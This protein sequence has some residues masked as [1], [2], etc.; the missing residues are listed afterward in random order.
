MELKNGRYGRYYR[1]TDGDCGKTAPV[2]TGVPC[3]VCKEGVLV[4]KYSA[5]RRRTFYSCN[6]YPDCRFAISERPVK[7]CP[8]CEEGVLAEKKGKLYC[9]N[10]TCSYSEEME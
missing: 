1:C 5:K 4:E 3:P 8:S 10:K 2:S 9:S 6:R 7:T